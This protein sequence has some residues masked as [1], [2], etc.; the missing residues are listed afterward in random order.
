[1]IRNTPEGNQTLYRLMPVEI[2]LQLAALAIFAHTYWGRLPEYHIVAF[3]T[4]VA[5]VN[6]YRFIIVFYLRYFG[7]PKAEGHGTF[8]SVNFILGNFFCGL[9]WGGGFVVLSIVSDNLS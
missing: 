6:F 8:A 3:I 1:M 7:D 4:V 5:S 9:S 2:L